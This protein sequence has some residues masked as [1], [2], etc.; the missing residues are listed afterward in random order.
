MAASVA[1][2]K[3]IFGKAL[4]LSSASERAAYLEQVCRGDARLRGEVESLLQA[5][6]RAVGFLAGPDADPATTLDERVLERPGTVIGPYRLMEQIGEGGMG[7]VFMAEQTEPVR[8]R[9]ALKVLKPGMDTRQVVARF[10]AERQALALMDH[11]NIARVFDG[12]ETA[13]GRPYFVMELVRGIPITDF[14]DQ[15]QLPVRE[16]LELFLHV[17]QAVQ[18]AHQKGVIHRD[19]KP[20]NV[21]VT[22]QDGTAVVK[23]I[24]FGVAKA[25]GQPLTDKTLFTGFAQ[26]IGTPLYMSPEQAA[27]SALDVD[28]RSDIYSL[29]V[30]LYELL[31]G[32][33]PFDQ[34]RLHQAGYD[35]M[36][37]IIR[38]EEPPRPSTRISTLG[39]AATTIST[40]RKSDPKRLSQL[41]RGE[42]DWI[43]MKC[44]EKDRNRRYES[45]SALAADVQRYLA[46]EPVLA[47]PA[48]AA[49]RF[50]KF[51]RKNRKLLAT[52]AAFAVLI[53]LAAG[54][55][56]WLAWQRAE[57]TQAV[58]LDL[59]R[60]TELLRGGHWDEARLAA[61]RAE[62]RLAPGDA[63]R[64][65]GRLAQVRAG[66]HLVDRLEQIRLEQA[67]VQGEHFDT[68]H[69]DVAYREAFREYGLDVEALDP[70]EAA[71]RLRA[72]PVCDAL[73][74]GIDDWALAKRRAGIAGW[75][76]LSTLAR[77][78]DPDPWRDRLR[79]TLLRGDWEAVVDLAR[80]PQVSSLPPSSVVLLG[81][82]LSKA[83]NLPVAVEVL[84]Q[85]QQRHPDDFWV[86]HDL[87][88]YLMLSK[89]VQAAQAAGFYRA[90]LAL[91]PQS[92]G[93]LN[94]LGNA[95]G[96]Q[97]DWAEAATV[98]REAIRLE[99]AFAMA[100]CNLGH[101]LREQGNLA[102]AVD[103]CR[104]A[105]R[106]KPDF[107]NAHFQLAEALA[108]EGK[109]PEAVAEYQEVLRLN[110][111]DTTTT[112]NLGNALYGQGKVSEAVTAFREAVRLQ[113]DYAEAHVNLGIALKKQGKLAEAVDEYLK[114]IRV[115]P[116]L[117]E[118]HYNL[119]LALTAQQNLPEAVV[120]YQAVIRLEPGH[121]AAHANLGAV[122]MDLGRFS[123]ARL[124][125][126]RT[127]Q[128][129]A[130]TDPMRAA[131][132]QDLK[133]CMALESLDQKLAAF[134]IGNVKPASAVETADLAWL[135]QRPYKRLYA[136]S[137][138]L[139]AEVFTA[140]PQLAEDLRSGR[141][142]DAACAAALAGCGQG[143]YVAALDGE[144][145]ARLRQQAVDWLRADLTAWMKLL[146][147]DLKQAGAA[148]AQTLQHWQTDTDLAGLRDTDALAKLPQAERAACQKLW[149]D[150]GALLAQVPSQVKEAPWDKL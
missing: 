85:A 22:M 93:V 39:Q 83:G 79:D 12:G 102:E 148:V 95:L 60:A 41:F 118:A 116:G 106:L 105:V 5:R 142:Y 36:R 76:A 129:Q 35:E 75:Q 123:E 9:V 54:G 26:M 6:Q 117:L 27:I 143:Q 114:A 112:Y 141:R 109:L 66:L 124:A 19:V 45:A 74:A 24:D 128:L 23:V 111:N 65:H 17:C 51:A 89:P 49:Y 69:G 127:L 13:S 136:A 88:L 87:G 64:L 82:T 16:R 43:V 7:L 68:A 14:C 29:G 62:A 33:T 32:T 72:S 53:V 8:R 110:R 28:T 47:C 133:K 137:A 92:P 34:E 98:L 56:L 147:R 115:K 103:E 132:T 52:A 44:L 21:L 25:I 59:D 78:A 120:E 20:S 145:R 1:D 122:L 140:A 113:P 55:G 40:Q 37:R 94:N 131:I 31:T 97:G 58:I 73:L 80:D 130:P 15:S 4:E 125:L 70:R 50:R 84:R 3:S 42:L 90:A 30:L 139:Y 149:A 10:E 119:A 2:I 71:E 100:H 81:W 67:A 57:R 61:G 135:C 18:H 134:L 104:E 126:E 108:K 99:P 146:G 150:V 121:I 91:R 107:G 11:L 77:R 63:E 38:E 101:V 138:R 144:Q 96:E 46:D 48:S 86:N